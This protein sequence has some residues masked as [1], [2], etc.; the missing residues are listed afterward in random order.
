MESM[1]E[2]SSRFMRS[3]DYIPSHVKP[4]PGA[5]QLHYADAFDSYFALTLRE[6]RSPS[7]VDMM[8]DAIKVEVNLM[9]SRKM[10]QKTD[11]ER[12]KVKDEA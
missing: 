1:Q 2:F 10:K 7:L 9:A 8:N 5:A 3:Y 4:P 11:Y 12:K 6:I